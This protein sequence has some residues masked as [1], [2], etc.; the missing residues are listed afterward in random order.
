[1]CDL[2]A[3]RAA[4]RVAIRRA[5]RA[6]AVLAVAAT[7]LVLAAPSEA[8]SYTA[9]V[10]DSASG[11]RVNSITYPGTGSSPAYASCPP[12]SSGHRIGV[13]A[14]SGI[15]AGTAAWFSGASA[16]FTAP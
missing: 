7:M 6:F 3:R 16:T 1:P 15:G 10:C 13:V 12:G 9:H 11:N 2:R 8:G 4:D 14:R 5:L